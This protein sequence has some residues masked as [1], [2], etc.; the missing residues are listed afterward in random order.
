MIKIFKVVAGSHFED[1]KEYTAGQTIASSV[2]LA[3]TF[4]GKFEDLGPFTPPA[5]APPAP[6]AAVAPHA[7]GKDKGAVRNK[8]AGTAS[9]KA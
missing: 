9:S 6:A 8:S 7:E 4:P 2:D 3:K 1:G 5:S